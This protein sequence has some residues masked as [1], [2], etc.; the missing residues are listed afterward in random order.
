MSD[1]VEGYFRETKTVQSAVL[2]ESSQNDEVRFPVLF[3]DHFLIIDAEVKRAN[4][5]EC[6]FCDHKGAV[7]ETVESIDSEMAA[8]DRQGDT[9]KIMGCPEAS[10]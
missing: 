3:L 8:D 9:T 7:L 4:M 5:L 6:S 2:R 1:E 10:T